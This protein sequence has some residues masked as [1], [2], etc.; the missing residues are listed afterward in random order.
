MDYQS[1]YIAIPPQICFLRFILYLKVKCYHLRHIQSNGNRHFRKRGNS[2]STAG[3]G[4]N[5]IKKH[6]KSNIID[7]FFC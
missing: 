3:N 5:E 6:K 7:K 4:N 1:M 2:V